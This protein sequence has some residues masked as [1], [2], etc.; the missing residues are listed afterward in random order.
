MLG[1]HVTMYCTYPCF[2]LRDISKEYQI[3][4]NDRTTLPVCIITH[5]GGYFTG[6]KLGAD[7]ELKNVKLICQVNIEW[8]CTSTA[9]AVSLPL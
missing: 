1:Q 8:N 5:T 6:D 7:L 4:Q 3:T 2:T 9:T